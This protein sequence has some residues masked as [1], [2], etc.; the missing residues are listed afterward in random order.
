MENVTI[1]FSRNVDFYPKETKNLLL[2][3]IW[4]LSKI[5]KV[6]TFIQLLHFH[7]ILVHEKDE[8]PLVLTGCYLGC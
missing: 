5:W 7:E 4:V 8:L 3:L 6:V 1:I 2:F